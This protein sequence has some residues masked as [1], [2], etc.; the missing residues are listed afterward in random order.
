[1]RGRLRCSGADPCADD[2][3]RVGDGE[4]VPA[5]RGE[6]DEAGNAERKRREVGGAWIPKRA[7]VARREGVTRRWGS[8]LACCGGGG[9]SGS[10]GG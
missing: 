1:M 3:R 5:D 6:A 10:G 2:A 8:V 4:S 9:G 7:G